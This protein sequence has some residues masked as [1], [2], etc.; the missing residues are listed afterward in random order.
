[1]KMFL[2]AA[3][4][5]SALT[6]AAAPALAQPYGGPPPA[7][8]DWRDHNGGPPATQ[9]DWRDRDHGP[10][11]PVDSYSLDQRMSWLQ[12]RINR[13]KQD[14]SLDWREARRL[15]HGLDRIHHDVWRA[16]RQ[17]GGQLND[18]DRQ[19]LE[20]RLDDLTNQIH[21]LRHNDERRPW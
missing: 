2:A 21:W 8:N 15:Q 20:A 17:M 5:A 10:Q 7:Q 12:D 4:A 14:G 9:N 18:Y 19:H 6:A 1:M 16:R 13:G 3:M 11:R